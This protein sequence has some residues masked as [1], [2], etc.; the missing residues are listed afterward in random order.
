[1]LQVRPRFRR[2]GIA[3]ALES[4]MIN[5]ALTREEIPFGQIFEG[6]EA[7]LHLQ[8]KLGLNVTDIILWWVW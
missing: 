4:H 2:R 3:A 6:N 1:M 5:E 7:S 8:R